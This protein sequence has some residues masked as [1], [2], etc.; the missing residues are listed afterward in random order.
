MSICSETKENINEILPLGIHIKIRMRVIFKW[1][2]G[3]LC[4][5]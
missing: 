5:R 2:I 3:K 4:M 1:N